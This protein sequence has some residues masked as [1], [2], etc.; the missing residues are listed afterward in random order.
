MR[1]LATT[2]YARL[3]GEIC[4]GADLVHCPHQVETFPDGE[5]YQR[6][7]EPVE[8][9]DVAIIGGTISDA[10]T[11]QLY[12][13][14]VGALE[15][16]A[17]SIVLVLPY[18]GYSTMDRAAKPGEVVTARTRA[19]LLSRLPAAPLGLTVVCLDLHTPSLPYYFDPSARVVHASA[20]TVIAEA[21]RR[22]GGADFVLASTDLG[23]AKAV[24]SLARDLGVPAGIAVKRRLG[25]IKTEV[26][27]VA[28]EVSGKRVV[29]YDDMIRSGASMISA[30]RAYHEAG[31]SSVSAV[32]T[33]GV[34]PGESYANL[35]H[36]GLFERI[37]CTDSHPRARELEAQGL[38]VESTAGVLR[39]ALLPDKAVG[40]GGPAVQVRPCD[41]ARVPG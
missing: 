34:L 21:A 40:S 9:E 41:W 27:A 17:R 22:L 38:T 33:H 8:R 20:R 28:A 19:L 37:A 32:A 36:T 16:G 24:Q 31:A 1:V 30:A 7:L 13:L 29:I 12:D 25:P 14:A 26:T 23:G 39:I 4:D 3:A 18:F 2:A 6:I 5:R 15:H 10:G 35:V 11:L